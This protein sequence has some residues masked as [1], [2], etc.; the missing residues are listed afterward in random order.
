MAR[1][2]LIDIAPLF[3]DAPLQ[4]DRLI[5]N[6]VYRTWKSALFDPAHAALLADFRNANPE[7]G[8]HFFDDTAMTRYMDD[9]WGQHP[10]CEIFHRTRFGAAKADIWRY[11]ILHERGGVYLDIDATLRF[12]LELLPKT[13][14]EVVS[15]ERNDLL[16]QL[17]TEAFP[18]DRWLIDTKPHISARLQSPDKVILNWC[19]LFQA[20]HPIL[21]YAIDS[22]VEHADR[23]RQKKFP[24]ML[25]AITHFSGPLLLTRA[26]WRHVGEGNS[27]VQIGTDFSGQGV[28]KAASLRGVY[29]D[30]PHY[31]RA[32]NQILLD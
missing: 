14:G 18:E 1:N 22:I 30:A 32:D 16:G 11:C 23:F 29:R 28:F 2:A 3:T 19:L 13:I 31:T 12:K 26:V 17:D 15:F 25:Q 7:F 10:I 6:R 20:K 5:P 27:V 4:A 9:S 21:G 8:F 24:N